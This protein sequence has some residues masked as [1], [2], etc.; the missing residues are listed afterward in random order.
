MKNV[1]KKLGRLLFTYGTPSPIRVSVGK[2][3][4]MLDPTTAPEDLACAD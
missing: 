1:L 2:G 3:G 4:R